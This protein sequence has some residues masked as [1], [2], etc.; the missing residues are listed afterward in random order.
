MYSFE[1]Q[2]DIL[3]LDRERAKIGG[4]FHKILIQC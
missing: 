1:L 3:N 4:K 2:V